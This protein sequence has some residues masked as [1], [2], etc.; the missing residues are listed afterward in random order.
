MAL[1]VPP[2]LHENLGEV[3]IGDLPPSAH[4]A[5]FDELYTFLQQWGRENGVCLV[6]KSSSNTRTIDGKPIATNVRLW[7]DHGGEPRPYRSSGIRRH[8]SRLWNCPFRVRASCKLRLNNMWEYAVVS[9]HEKHNHEPS[10][11]A[12]AHPIHRRRTAEYKKAIR[13]LSAWGIKACEI[14]E[15][16]KLQYPE[17]LFTGRDIENERQTARRDALAQTHHEPVKAPAKDKP[18]NGTPEWIYAKY[19]LVRTRWYEKKKLP[20]HLRTNEVYRKK[21]KFPTYS[22]SKYAWCVGNFLLLR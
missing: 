21:R 7:Y 20:L 15:M 16:L 22:K 8:G 18:K 12:V 19:K 4:F 11:H 1:H 5:T 3:R 17:A 14:A 6:K 9:G 10:L 13:E 2:A